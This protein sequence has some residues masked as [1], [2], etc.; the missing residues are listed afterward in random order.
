MSEMKLGDWFETR[1]RWEKDGS[2]GE[3]FVTLKDGHPKWLQGAIREAHRG[4]LPDDWIYGECAAVCE[5]VDAGDLA[6]PGESGDLDSN[7][8]DAL[9]S[10]VDGRVDPYTKDIFAWAH[11]M[12]LTDLFAEAEEM[13]EDAAL[14]EDASVA[15]RLSA[16]QSYAIHIVASVLLEGLHGHVSP[17]GKLIEDSESDSESDEAVN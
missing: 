3:A 15:K 5:A 1:H 4:V 6:V 8:L 16:I 12:C 10:F 2:E 14:E 17:E 11:R 9:D 13:A 7:G